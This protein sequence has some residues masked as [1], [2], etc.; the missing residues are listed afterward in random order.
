MSAAALIQTVVAG[1]SAWT[2][3]GDDLTSPARA[4]RDV[5]DLLARMDSEVVYDAATVTSELVTNACL[6]TRSGQAGGHVSLGVVATR[7]AVTITVVDRGSDA[8]PTISPDGRTETGRGLALC[9]DLGDLTID[10][11]TNG[12]MVT[13]RIPL[14]DAV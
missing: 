6:H 3:P 12:R 2:Y 10:T 8:T 9:A 4:R 7:N 1:M 5:R 14:E 11:W 13:V